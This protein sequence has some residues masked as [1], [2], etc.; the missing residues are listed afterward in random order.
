MTARL[1]ERLDGVRQTGERRWVARCPA[2]EDT[3]PSLSVRELD[4]GRT[5]IHCWSGGCDAA[6]IVAAIG[7]TLADLFPPRER[8]EHSITPVR[9][10]FSARD[11]LECLDLEAY[12]VQIAASDMARGVALDDDSLDRLALAATRIHAAREV[13]RG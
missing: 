11:A 9:N 10:P 3:R 12:A 7:L 5:L 2:H 6:D 13:C 8:R 1:L 4:D